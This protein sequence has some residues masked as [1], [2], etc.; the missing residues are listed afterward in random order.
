[1][2]FIT[3]FE[4]YA[5]QAFEVGAVDYLQ[6]PV[7]R[8]RFAAA[9]SRAQERLGRRSADYSQ[10][11]VASAAVA[12]RAR[13][14]RTRFVVRRGNTHHMVPADQVDWMDVAD[15]Y[16]ESSRRCKDASLARHDEAGGGRA[17]SR[18]RSSVF[19]GRRSWPW[20]GS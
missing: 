20:I 19:I 11:L 4:Q 13:G 16:L 9:V 2:V 14:F 1:M 15:N 6:K 5:L 10:S 12:E 18:Q 17:R 8:Q 3:A 7:T